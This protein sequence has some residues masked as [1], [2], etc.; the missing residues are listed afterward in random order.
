MTARV[1]VGLGVNDFEYS[2]CLLIAADV[3]LAAPDRVCVSPAVLGSLQAI[4]AATIECLY[5]L[6]DVIYGPLDFGGNVL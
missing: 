3:P 2:M 5:P 1:R 4:K 6:L